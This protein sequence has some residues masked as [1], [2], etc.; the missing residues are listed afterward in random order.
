MVSGS[1]RTVRG[2]KEIAVKAGNAG[3]VDFQFNGKKVDLRA[4]YGEVKTVTFGPAGMS[5]S[6]TPPAPQP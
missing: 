6:A 4:D 2:R 5:R 3:G 1:E